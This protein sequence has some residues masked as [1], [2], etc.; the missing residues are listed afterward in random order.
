MQIV[1]HPAGVGGVGGI[2]AAVEVGERYRT[3]VGHPVNRFR[4]RSRGS[5]SPLA[6][7]FIKPSFKTSNILR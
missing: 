2:L 7:R 4:S 6:P 5:V 3:A 1:E